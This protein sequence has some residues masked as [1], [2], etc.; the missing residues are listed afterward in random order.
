MT[1]LFI[2][3]T[4]ILQNHCSFDIFI[5]T[6]YIYFIFLALVVN[7]LSPNIP[8]FRSRPN[9]VSFNVGETATLFC[10]V[11]DLRTR[12]VSTNTSYYV[13]DEFYSNVANDDNI[14]FYLFFYIMIHILIMLVV[15]I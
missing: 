14:R 12:F 1:L 6:L 13:V 10:S 7:G 5:S 3:Y 11:S 9:N 2:Q 15:L 8:F 4:C